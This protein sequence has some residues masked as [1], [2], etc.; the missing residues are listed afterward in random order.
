MTV[1]LDNAATTRVLPCARDA[2]LLA[3]TECFGNPGSLHGVGKAARDLL[4]KSRAQVAEALGCSPDCIT[5][6]SG[7]SESTNTALRGA[8]HKTRRLGKHIVSTAVEHEATL[9]TLRQLQQEGY[10]VTLIQPERDG[11]V[12][13]EK[14][15]AAFRADTV[16]LSMMAVCNETGAVLPVQECAAVLKRIQPDALVHVDAVQAFCKI[17]LT[18]HQVDLM[19]LSAHKICGVKGVGA[20]Y[21]KKGLALRPLIYGGGQENGLRSGTEPL[22]QIA[23]F[24]AAAEQRMKN[25]A[26]DTAQMATLREKL[27]AWAKEQG[28]ALQTPDVGAPHIVNLSTKVGRSEVYIRAL[29]DRGICISGGS[30][31]ARGKQS[32]VLSAMR[33]EKNALDAAVRV[34]LCP[35]T[36]EEEIT[37][38]CTALLETMRLF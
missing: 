38:F 31:C 17:P 32:H 27:M 12:L 8:V 23:A 24:G 36:T 25:F 16:L 30:A 6:T 1:Y 29:S 2:A 22:P 9:N 18:L 20:L 14:V 5:F 15:I 21:V 37:A 4:Q 28:F 3:M 35:E 26:Q 33:G 13:A 7:G 11:N 34:S 19:S 10:E